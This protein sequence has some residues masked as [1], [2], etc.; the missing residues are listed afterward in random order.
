MKTQDIKNM[1]QAMLRVQ[2]NQKAATLKALARSAAASEKGKAAVTLAPKAPWDKQK[3]EMSSKE[4]MKKGL[5]NSKM[6]PVDSKELKG[7]FKD[8]EDKDIDNDGDADK[9]DEYL[10]NRR[11]AISKNVKGDKNEVVINPKKGKGNEGADTA[12][13]EARWPIYN[14]IME[15]ISHTSGATAPEAIDS[16]E[17]P[18]GKKAKADLTKGAEYDESEEKGHTDAVAA[19]RAGPRAKARTG[20]NTAGDKAIINKPSDI[21][22]KK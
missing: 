16:K 6:D 10:H 4:K 13:E 11:K 14:R 7:K 5:Y 2:E 18:G 8:R 12:M 20:D 3:T 15:K 17:N 1:G 9:S 22:A 21:T 19:G